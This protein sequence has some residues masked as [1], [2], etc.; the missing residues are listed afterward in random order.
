MH[1]KFLFPL[2]ILLFTF[3][4]SSAGYVF[5]EKNTR[6]EKDIFVKEEVIGPLKGE[7]MELC[8]SECEKLK[9]QSS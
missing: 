9:L 5:L 4:V 1:K 7:L 8:A 2:G 6:T 3:I